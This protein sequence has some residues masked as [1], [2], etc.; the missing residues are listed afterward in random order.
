MQEERLFSLHRQNGLWRFFG[1]H[2]L[3]V[4]NAVVSRFY[5]VAV[6][7]FVFVKCIMHALFGTAGRLYFC[8]GLCKRGCAKTDGE[9]E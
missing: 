9:E 6:M 7:L 3:Y 2:F 5:F 8:F 4:C 1:F